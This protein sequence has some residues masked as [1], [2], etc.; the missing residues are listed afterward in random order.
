MY[1]I[2]KNYQY[3]KKIPWV[4]DLLFQINPLYFAPQASKEDC[5]AYMKQIGSA[6]KEVNLRWRRGT[7]K[8]SDIRNIQVNEDE[9]IISYKGGMPCLTFT[10]TEFK[11]N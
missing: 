7:V 5:R 9:I 8:L 3:A 10:I 11:K 4:A 6:I 1:I 2:K